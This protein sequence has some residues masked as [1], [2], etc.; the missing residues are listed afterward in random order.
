MGRLKQR[1]RKSPVSTRTNGQWLICWRCVANLENIKEL[2]A[3]IEK[4]HGCNSTHVESAPVREVFE[5][6]A[7]WHGIVEVFDL[8]GH[9]KAKRCYAW[10]YQDRRETRY[11]TVL[12][13]P[14]VES[15]QSA[16]RA[17]IANKAQ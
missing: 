12:E 3:V 11:V 13:I 17:A 1:R 9:P 7:L 5:G 4:V 14:P 6:Q 8:I 16:V 15:P 2:R 10:S